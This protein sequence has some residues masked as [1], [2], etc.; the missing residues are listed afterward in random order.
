MI[1]A[2]GRLGGH[3]LAASFNSIVMVSSGSSDAGGIRI[4]APTNLV[5]EQL[6][7]CSPPLDC[8]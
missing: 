2:N 3:A 7:V 6:L 8:D 5:I 1:F 4:P